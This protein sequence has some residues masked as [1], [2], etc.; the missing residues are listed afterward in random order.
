MD[1]EPQAG[2]GQDKDG[3]QQAG[4]GQDKDGAQQA[5]RGH[6]KDGVQRANG[7]LQ[8][9]GLWGSTNILLAGKQGDKLLREEG[10]EGKEVGDG[11]L[12]GDPS[13][14][15]RHSAFPRPHEVTPHSILPHSSRRHST[16]RPPAFQSASRVK[17]QLARAVT[18]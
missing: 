1:G 7:A 4:R 14:T 15:Q 2:R 16:F 17:A 10:K 6:D 12:K 9:R 18:P 5:G 11:S 3:A 13:P 8:E